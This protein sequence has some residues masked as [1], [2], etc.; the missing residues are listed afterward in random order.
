M[1]RHAFLGT[2]TREPCKK[3]GGTVFYV[4]NASCIKCQSE[5]NA[6]RSKKL[7]A[8]PD[9]RQRKPRAKPDTTGAVNSFLQMKW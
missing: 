2:F 6:A 1:G 8:D 3:C 9:R 7:K 4:A 5:R